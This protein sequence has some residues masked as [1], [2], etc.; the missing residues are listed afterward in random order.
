MQAWHRVEQSAHSEMQS[1]SVASPC[2]AHSW[3]QAS[4]LATQVASASMS[5]WVRSSTSVISVFSVR[6][7]GLPT[8]FSLYLSAAGG[9][10]ITKPGVGCAISR[11]PLEAL[12]FQP[13]GRY[14]VQ[15]VG[16]L[17]SG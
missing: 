8:L 16:G 11:L 3:V 17:L 14:N 13:S 4:H 7:G 12:T 10:T 5:C 1:A 15:L 2:R 9:S 6:S